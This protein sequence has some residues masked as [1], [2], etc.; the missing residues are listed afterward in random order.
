VSD[1][2]TRS[3]ASQSRQAWAGVNSAAQCNRGGPWGCYV[4][5]KRAS[6][7]RWPGLARRNSFLFDLFKNFSNGRDLG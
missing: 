1:G 2:D 5:G 6:V 4:R 3:V 7:G